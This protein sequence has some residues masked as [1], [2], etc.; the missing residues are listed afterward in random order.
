ML[1]YLTQLLERQITQTQQQC[2]Q[3]C[4]AV[5]PSLLPRFLYFAE[6]ARFELP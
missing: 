5:T 2:D 6:L 3:L 1:L 4:W